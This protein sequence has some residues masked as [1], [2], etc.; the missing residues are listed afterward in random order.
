M[1]SMKRDRELIELARAG[2]SREQIAKRLNITP[3]ALQKAVAR[4]GVNVGPY[5]PIPNG[6]PKAQK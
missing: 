4:L 6:R 3:A 2:L 1:M 5:V